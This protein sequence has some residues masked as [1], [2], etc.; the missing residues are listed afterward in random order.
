MPLEVSSLDISE[1][2]TS[3]S[4]ASTC[5][6]LAPPSPTTSRCSFKVNCK[7]VSW[8][9]L[10]SV[11]SSWQGKPCSHTLHI[12]VCRA[13]TVGWWCSRIEAIAVSA[14]SAQACAGFSDFFLAL[15]RD[16]ETTC[17]SL[18]DASTANGAKAGF[19]AAMPAAEHAACRA[20]VTGFNM[21]CS[22][23]GKNCG[24][25]GVTWVPRCS[26]IPHARCIASRRFKAG[27]VGWI[28]CCTR[29]MQSGKAWTV[30]VSLL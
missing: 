3:T 24:Q 2:Q 17:I 13:A 9:C 7:S 30:N 10:P 27:I 25:C 11:S 28:S 19:F 12:W 15:L 23:C 26:N 16:S 1:L 8:F 21:S 5:G 22:I 18:L 29:G 14:A 6:M 20:S 4:T